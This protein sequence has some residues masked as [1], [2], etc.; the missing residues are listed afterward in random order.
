MLKNNKKRTFINVLGGN[1]SGK[2]TRVSCLVKWM[3]GKFGAPELIIHY[4]MKKKKE[5]EVG[6]IYNTSIGKVFILGKFN[7]KG[8][9]VGLDNA[10]FSTYDSRYEFIKFMFE[11][12]DLRVFLQEGYFNNRGYAFTFEK[13]IENGSNVDE[14]IE[15]FF[16]YT[17]VE[18]FLERTNGR[19]GKERGLDW[20]ENAPG[21]RDNVS[22]R[23]HLEKLF[24][25]KENG[26]TKTILLD[27]PID[28]TKDYFIQ[29]LFNETCECKEEEIPKKEEIKVAS[30][31]EDW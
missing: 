12:Y 4:S 28:E 15:V 19:T 3:E 24:E 17:K 10:D 1:A 11:N 7:N 26:E 9:W 6:R 16:L 21:W 5:T 31:L 20:A 23:K 27:V 13:V 30:A 8:K 22:Q 2:S 25:T 18:Q 29:Q 14:V